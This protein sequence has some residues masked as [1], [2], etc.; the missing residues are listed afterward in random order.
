MKTDIQRSTW[1]PAALRDLLAEHHV[2]A[3]DLQATFK[4]FW[5]VLG[6][7]LAKERFVDSLA[8]VQAG[9]RAWTVMASNYAPV[10]SKRVKDE[11]AKDRKRGEENGGH[12]LGLQ[13][14]ARAAGTTPAAL[15]MWSIRGLIDLAYRGGI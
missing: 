6:E 2:T 5:T 9:Q 4:N 10:P 7:E 11:I 1:T 3:I 14:L 8:I 13:A 12:Y 15:R